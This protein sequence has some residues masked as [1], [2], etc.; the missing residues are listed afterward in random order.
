MRMKHP[1]YLVIAVL[2]LLLL[3][4]IQVSAQQ[5]TSLPQSPFL[6]GAVDLLGNLSVKGDLKVIVVNNGFVNVTVSGILMD[7]FKFWSGRL[8]L[9]PNETKTFEHVVNFNR[10]TSIHNLTFLFEDAVPS[11]VS[12]PL[13]PQ[14]NS[15]FW[16]G[17][18]PVNLAVELKV[19]EPVGMP[20]WAKPG[21]YMKV[22]YSAF[23]SNGGKQSDYMELTIKSV[24]EKS[25]EYT[26]IMEMGGRKITNKASVFEPNVLLMHPF[27]IKWIENHGYLPYGR[28]KI[29]LLGKEEIPTKYGVIKTLHLQ[30]MGVSGFTTYKIEMWVDPNT[31]I[32]VKSFRTALSASPSGISYEN[33]T[34]TLDTVKG[35]SLGASKKGPLDWIAA[36]A[37]F[38]VLVVVVYVLQRRRS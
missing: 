11:K 29:V 22:H 7:G 10:S 24:D 18:Y 35:V 27:Y 19:K 4:A 15:S 36:G 23:Q 5:N 1:R 6:V 28:W 16:L 13:T 9:K 33:A 17:R 21:F 14:K 38:V 26:Y 12:I 3:P 30:M 32:M 8:V 37:V 20:V 25:K 34:I 2:A 31:G